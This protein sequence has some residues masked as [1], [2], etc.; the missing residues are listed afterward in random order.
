[1][2]RLGIEA[3]QKARVLQQE[4]TPL[5]HPQN[6]LDCPKMIETLLSSPALAIRGPNSNWDNPT[7]AETRVL[8]KTGIS[9]REIARLLSS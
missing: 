8:A 6:L 1:M 7:R 2:L 3:V 9:Q 4:Y 5:L